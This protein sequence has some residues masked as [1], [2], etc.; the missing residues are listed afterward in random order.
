MVNEHRHNPDLD[1]LSVISALI[2]LSYATTS[3]V[4]F[5]TQSI[6]LQL[7][8]FL[9]EVRINFITIVAIVVAIL[10]AAGAD[11]LIAGHPHNP[12]ASRWHH[13]LVPSFTAAAIGIP[14]GSIE[15]SPAWWIVFGLGGILLIGVLAAEY[16]SVDPLDIR[17]SFAVLGLTAVSFSIFL[18][19]VFAITGAGFRLYL[20]LATLI[21]TVFL[22]TARTLYL[23]LR[24]NWR[25]AWAAGVTLIIAQV[26]A[27]LFYL[28][29]QPLQVSLILLGLLYSLI[30]IAYSIEDKRPLKTIWIEPLVMFT[31]FT[32]LGFIL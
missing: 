3:F 31:A 19:L 17:Y 32:T 5:P 16:I 22:I 6:E 15:V 27:A 24:G 9:F 2:L 18:I 11:W 12:A 7:P 20:L 26:A 13:W 28:P 23:R 14:L 21:P 1:R 25:L 29:L 30:V 10:A 8:G 4:S